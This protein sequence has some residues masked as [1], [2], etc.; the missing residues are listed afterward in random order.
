MKIEIT[1]DHIN[2]VNNMNIL[3]LIFLLNNNALYNYVNNCVN[4]LYIFYNKNYVIETLKINHKSGMNIIS[5]YFDFK[6]T[7]EGYDYWYELNNKW[8]DFYISKYY[9]NIK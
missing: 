2:I 1:K 7:K 4:N 3:L 9:P 8:Q 6:T 5:R